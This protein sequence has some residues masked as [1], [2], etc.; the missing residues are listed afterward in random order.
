LSHILLTDRYFY[1]RG[2]FRVDPSLEMK[3]LEAIFR[4]GV[5][6]M[7]LPGGGITKALITMLSNWRHSGFQVNFSLDW[8]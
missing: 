2:M 6:K 4:Y 3:R 1:G 8:L 7:L 5:F